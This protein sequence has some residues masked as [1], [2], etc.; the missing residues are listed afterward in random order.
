MPSKRAAA[1]SIQAPKKK[2]RKI[3][4][5]SRSKPKHHLPAEI[6]QMLVGFFGLNPTYSR[7]M[8]N[9]AKVEKSWTGPALR[10]LYTN[11]QFPTYKAI[12]SYV[13]LVAEKPE[14][15]ELAH[16]ML[17]VSL[18]GPSCCNELLTRLAGFC[19]NITSFYINK[20][21]TQ[22][23]DDDVLNAMYSKVK[24]LTRL[25][26]RNRELIDGKTL[27]K[28]CKEWRQLSYLDLTDVPKINEHHY[29]AILK[30][31]PQLKVFRVGHQSNKAGKIGDCITDGCL[32]AIALRIPNLKALELINC[33]RISNIPL[34]NYIGT[35]VALS[36]EYLTLSGCRQVSGITLAK[37]IAACPALRFVN[38]S[39]SSFNDEALIYLSGVR[40]PLN[41]PHKEI[42][43]RV[44]R[45]ITQF[46][47]SRCINVTKYPL[48]AFAKVLGSNIQRGDVHT[49]IIY[50]QKMRPSTCR[51]W[52]RKLA[53][54]YP[55]LLFEACRQAFKIDV[56]EEFLHPKPSMPS[57]TAP[58][59]FVTVGIRTFTLIV[60]EEE[61]EIMDSTGRKSG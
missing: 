55:G 40:A 16:T 47:L 26:L 59:R 58:S 28:A 31:L 46:A 24:N 42:P 29:V 54:E 49:C 61:P 11:V 7:D 9:L 18:S 10:M 35:K 17:F 30:C 37:L 39:R 6:V 2:K 33:P 41:E 23:M 1:Q 32:R 34:L 43:Q 53:K 50:L 60:P 12:E 52:N 8:L 51:E 38:V 20:S 4:R 14:L 27:I 19:P 57:L 5:K 45:Y 36:L 22:W 3:N 56:A 44:G 48:H 25:T 21:P 13:K 15:G